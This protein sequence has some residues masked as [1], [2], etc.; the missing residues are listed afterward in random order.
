MNHFLDHLP[1]LNLPPRT[2]YRLRRG[3]GH[4]TVLVAALHAAG[5]AL[6]PSPM[7]LARKTGQ[8]DLARR[9]GIARATVAN[10]ALGH[11][12]TIR[13][14]SAVAAAL[15]VT[16]RVV[17]RK[18][19]EA[20]HSSKDQTWQT[21]RDVLAAI[22]QA[23]ARTKFDLDPCSPRSD[24]PV[25][26]MTHWTETDDGLSRPWHGLAFVNPP[27]SRALPLWVAKC[28]NEATHGAVVVALVPS[29]TDTKW[30]DQSV[31]DKANVIMI[32][33][34]LRFGDSQNSA[35]FPSALLVW[36]NSILAERILAA[37][38]GGWMADTHE[39]WGLEARRFS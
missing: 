4:L 36:G 38:S 9:A 20:C 23:A 7:D 1:A 26:A 25:P 16:P 3:Q 32:K 2:L 22:L 34:R 33:G 31:A 18:A 5:Y 17:K 27:Y 21:P 10:L 11:Q 35:P 6:L 19:Y 29:R 12:G 24:G 8:R 13:S 30:W 14:Y 15:R 28:L 39:G 37:I